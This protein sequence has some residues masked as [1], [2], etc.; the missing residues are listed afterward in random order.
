VPAS[1]EQRVEEGVRRYRQF[2]QAKKRLAEIGAQALELVED[3]G[4]SLLA[5]YPPDDPLPPAK[6]RGSKAGTRRS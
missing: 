6:R 4:R 2:K 3:L 5:P 1:D